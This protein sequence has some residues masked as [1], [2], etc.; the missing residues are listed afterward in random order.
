MRN[1]SLFPPPLLVQTDVLQPGVQTT[2]K[3]NSLRRRDRGGNMEGERVT[4][5]GVEEAEEGGWE[6]RERERKREEKG[7]RG[8]EGGEMRDVGER[9]E[10]RDERRGIG[11]E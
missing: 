8:E 6:M 2:Q 10:Q 11:R 1:L 5:E 4:R 3:H 7:E 9:E